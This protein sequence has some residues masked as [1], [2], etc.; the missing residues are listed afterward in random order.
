MI[1]YTS[2]KMEFFLDFLGVFFI[3]FDTAQNGCPTENASRKATNTALIEKPN[4]RILNI[5]IINQI[6][7]LLTRLVWL[8]ARIRI[9][10]NMV[11]ATIDINFKKNSCLDMN[12]DQNIFFNHSAVYLMISQ[13][14]C[15]KS[16]YIAL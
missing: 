7:A 9:V 10:L 12:K 1:D 5:I 4:G 16:S 13:Q 8:V 3:V 11:L 14:K 2:N 6:Q 15:Y